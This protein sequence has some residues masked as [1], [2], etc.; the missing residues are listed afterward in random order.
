MGFYDLRSFGKI[1][2]YL[3]YGGHICRWGGKDFMAVVVQDELVLEIPGPG[4]RSVCSCN[5]G[6]VTFVGFEVI[7]A[8]EDGLIIGPAFGTE[9]VAAEAIYSM[10]IILA[11]KGL[12]VERNDGYLAPTV[13]AVAVGR[14]GEDSNLVFG[15]RM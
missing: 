6:V 2:E 11:V 3:E 14:E 8:P 9:S 12:G 13:G 15:L 5:P 7:F 10:L 1:L 4:W